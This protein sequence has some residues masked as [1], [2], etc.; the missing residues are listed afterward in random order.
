MNPL[1]KGQLCPVMSAR[2][3]VEPSIDL[4]PG[5][6]EVGPVIFPCAKEHCAWYHRGLKTCAVLLIATTTPPRRE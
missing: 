6:L 1:E 5:K 4:T 2:L 3:L